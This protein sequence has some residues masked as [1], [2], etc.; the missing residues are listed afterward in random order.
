[1]RVSGDNPAGWRLASALFGSLTVLG[2]FLWTYVLVGDY[3]LAL[4]AS[5][6]TIFNNF[7]FVMS[8][9]A[10]LD[11][12]YFA[13]VVWALFAFTAAITLAWD[14]PK[15]RSLMLAAGVLF[16]LG[17]SCKWTAVVSMA[18][19]AAVAGLLFVGDRHNMRQIGLTVLVL[20]FVILPSA[21]YCVSYWPQFMAIHKPFAIQDFFAMNVYIWQSHV[22]APGNP[23]IGCPWYAWF[24][25]TTPL[26]VMDYLMGN[27]VVMWGGIGALLVCALKFLRAPALSE[28]LVISLYAANVLQWV[29][30]PEKMTQYYYYYPPATFLSLAIVL[31]CAALQ[32]PKMAGVRPVVLAVGAAGVF[33][34]ICY[35]KMAALQAPFDC[36][37]TCW[38]Y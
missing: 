32:R 16:G 36:A 17:C 33:F 37:L 2:I 12:F 8:R 29:L 25:K 14:L 24:F 6:L 27:Y 1:M 28:G 5:L 35:P 20:T 38:P 15:R 21:V 26:R 23:A 3:A 4:A 13:F 19:T 18:V 22:I 9:L 10:M 11:V 31:A 30:I 7:L 34:L